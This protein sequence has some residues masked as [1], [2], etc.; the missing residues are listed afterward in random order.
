MHGCFG[1]T[2]TREGP[3]DLSIFE[4]PREAVRMHAPR[5]ALVYGAVTG[6]ASM[7]SDST[8]LNPSISLVVSGI[9]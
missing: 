6:G 3:E 5:R 8:R 2:L 7:P 4:P 9:V 1:D